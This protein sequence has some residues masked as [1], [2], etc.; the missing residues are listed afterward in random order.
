MSSI[1]PRGRR[2]L[3]AVLVT[4]ALLVVQ[5]CVTPDDDSDIPWN[6]PQP[7]EGSPFLPGVNP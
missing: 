3:A 1:D 5:G 6:A 7:W 2:F 4:L